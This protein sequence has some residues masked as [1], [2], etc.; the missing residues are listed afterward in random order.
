MKQN[1]LTRLLQSDDPDEVKKALQHIKILIGNRE[2]ITDEI[3]ILMLQSNL[4]VVYNTAL[5]YLIQRKQKIVLSKLPV[6]VQLEKDAIFNHACYEL[7]R[8]VRKKGFDTSKEGAIERFLYVVCKKYIHKVSRNR[9]YG[10]SD[11][12]FDIDFDKIPEPPD[13]PAPSFYDADAYNAIEE[14]FSRLGKGCKEILMPR[15]FEGKKFKEI[16]EDTNR[17]I[18]V[19]KVTASR[20]MKKLRTWV[21]ENDNLAKYIKELLSN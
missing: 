15:Y 7:W 13:N 2:K 12:D 16:E 6:P 3:L 20:C 1:E 18:G 19:I 21:A 10:D 11:I 9:R 17:D 4:K 8:Y 14:L 5:K